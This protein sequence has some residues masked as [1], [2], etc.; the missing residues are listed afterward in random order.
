MQ[1]VNVEY[2]EIST[3]PGEYTPIQHKFE[4]LAEEL[5][6]PHEGASIP[7]D[8]I[9]ETPEYYKIDQDEDGMSTQGMAEVIIAKHRNGSLDTA[10]LK[11]IGK[12]TKFTDFD[13]RPASENPFSGMI[14][15]ES[16]VNTSRDS[17][18]PPRPDEETP[19]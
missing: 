16:R 6:K 1:T 4:T 12:F 7:A 19:F 17:A 10:K 3:Y 13:D 8:N 15:R 9:C 5:S 11:F 2:P 18:P 14:T